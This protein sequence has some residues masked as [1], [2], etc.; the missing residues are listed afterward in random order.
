MYWQSLWILVCHC[1]MCKSQKHL[2]CVLNADTE[3]NALAAVQ[4]SESPS[5]INNTGVAVLERAGKKTVAG[6]KIQSPEYN[7]NST[8]PNYLEKKAV[9]LPSVRINHNLVLLR[10]TTCLVMILFGSAEVKVKIRKGYQKYFQKH[11]LFLPLD[12]NGFTKEWRMEGEGNSSRRL[13]NTY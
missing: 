2:T 6:G 11:L 3:M 9:M 4:K 5:L 10:R 1:Y 7:K 12:Y 13:G 8:G